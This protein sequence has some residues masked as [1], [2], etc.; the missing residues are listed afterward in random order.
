[1]GEPNVQEDLKD[2]VHEL[3]EINKVIKITRE[4]LKLLDTKKKD[5]K[6]K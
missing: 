5:V 3:A 6:K 1:M 2:K 4:K